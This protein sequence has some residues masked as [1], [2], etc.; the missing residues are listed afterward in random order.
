MNAATTAG[1]LKRLWESLGDFR[2]RLDVLQ[3]KQKKFGSKI[4]KRLDLLQQQQQ[5]LVFS[6]A[7]YK[8]ETSCQKRKRKS[9][10]KL[11]IN[12]NSN[13]NS[14]RHSL[15]PQFAISSPSLPS[16]PSLQS[17][18]ESEKSEQERKQ[19]T[20]KLQ[21]FQTFQ[22]FQTPGAEEM[23][24]KEQ[25]AR[26]TK[27][28][29]LVYASPWKTF[30]EP[31]E[32]PEWAATDKK[33]GIIA[34]A[35]SCE[36]QNFRHPLPSEAFNWFL[37]KLLLLQESAQHSWLGSGEP[38]GVSWLELSQSPV[39]EH[40]SARL[41]PRQYFLSFLRKLKD[42]GE[43][44][45]KVKWSTK[46]A[47]HFQSHRLLPS[48]AF[49]RMLYELER[50]PTP[51]YPLS[52]LL[53]KRW[54][55][56]FSFSFFLS[57]PLPPSLPFPALPVS[58]LSPDLT[59]S[60]PKDSRAGRGESKRTNKKSKTGENRRRKST[61]SWG[62]RSRRSRISKT[63]P[64]L[65]SLLPCRDQRNQA[66]SGT[67]AG[68]RKGSGKG[69]RWFPMRNF[70]YL[71]SPVFHYFCNLF[72][73]YLDLVLCLQVFHFSNSKMEQGWSKGKGKETRMVEGCSQGLDDL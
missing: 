17:L 38:S 30:H 54:A 1:K 48:V 23:E 56:C 57:L 46:L 28:R 51:L 64:L 24:I 20:T 16:L 18:G 22:T 25:A 63:A 41:D 14:K 73:F 61:C 9:K 39:C 67:P 11:S 62:R 40:C 52:S 60:S 72:V 2:D 66:P 19:E 53:Y 42:G 59:Q 12:S 26:K 69:I 36:G 65:Q 31:E 6:F 37:P 58:S 5:E 35:E 32:F 70:R 15:S 33:D 4:Q 21:P 3:K 44:P 29:R 13:R 34:E 8:A 10:R 55:F 45:A 50:S 47:H 43:V 49:T 7:R 27:S 68:M 71:F